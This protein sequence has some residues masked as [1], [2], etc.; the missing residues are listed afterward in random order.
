MEK[1]WRVGGRSNFDALVLS[2]FSFFRSCPSSF[3]FFQTAL[4]PRSSASG[5]SGLPLTSWPLRRRRQW[6]Q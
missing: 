2:V 4:S 3:C 6:R 5:L 1:S